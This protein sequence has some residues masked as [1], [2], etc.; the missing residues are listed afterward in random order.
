MCG[1]SGIFTFDRDCGE[2]ERAAVQA[3]NDRL[4]HRGPD[5][6]GLYLSGPIALGHRRLSIID[7]AAGKQPM[8]N[9]DRTVWVVFNGE[10]YNH[11]E[12]QK[13]LTGKGHRFR[14]R[15]DTE[16]LVHLYEEA[17]EKMFSRLNGMFAIAL[18][19]G[20]AKK[21]ILARDR[22]GKK[23]LYYHFDDHHRL[24]FASELKALLALGDCPARVDPD[25]LDHY[26]GFFF[27]PSPETIFSGVAKLAPA[28]YLVCQDGKIRTERYWRVDFG[29][30]YAGSRQDAAVELAGLLGDAVDLRLESEVP[31]GAFLSGGIDSSAIVALM[32]RSMRQPVKTT[33]IGFGESGFNELAYARVVAGH[34]QTDHREEI[35]PAS[36]IEHLPRIVYHFDEPF[37]DS[38]ALPTFL[39]CQAARR[40]VTV[41]LSGDG[42]DESFAGYTRYPAALGEERWRNA[43]PAVWRGLALNLARSCFS[44]LYRGFT[45]LENLN[46]D[47]AGAAARTVFCFADDMKQA[48]YRP[49]FAQQLHGPSAAQ[50][51]RESF[52]DNGG[53]PPLSRLQAYDLKSYLPEDILTKVDRMSMAHSLEV[54]APLLDYRVVELAASLPPEWKLDQSGGKVIFK[55]ALK[56]FLPAEVF[57]RKKMGFSIPVGEWFRNQWRP[58]G[59]RF[60]LGERFFERGYFEPAAI[61]KIWHSHQS[62]RP[63]II[64]LG[65]RLWALLVLEIWHRLFIDGDSIERVTM[66]LTG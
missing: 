45:P 51:F 56:D 42:G 22:V 19:D 46:Q 29:R 35:L 41:A 1:I 32:A 65:E 64:D 38:S 4:V 39:L 7:V 16:V 53:L 18:W 62:N 25:S 34:C 15:S 21:L 36:F 27:V 54:R 52:P 48:L 55:E 50:R 5:D 6:E 26:L 59:E 58:L 8:A 37:A 66:E 33:T 13:E 47:L 40:H 24:A 3:M 14:T 17:G 43:V 23:P 20:R 63:W 30:R 49:A 60:L 28:S 10:I 57:S 2:A 12:L 31:L 9:E 11:R 61:K 44:P